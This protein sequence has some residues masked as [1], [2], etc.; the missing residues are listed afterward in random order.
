MDLDIIF[1]VK[2]HMRKKTDR[3]TKFFCDRI[4]F[5]KIFFPDIIPMLKFKN[6][7]Q[8]H[9]FFCKCDLST[10]SSPHL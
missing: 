10:T 7:L 3:K 5:G 4:N 2:V 9:N 8:Q 6:L 1:A